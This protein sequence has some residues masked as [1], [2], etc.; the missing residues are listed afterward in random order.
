MYWKT[1]SAMSFFS[2]S[3]NAKIYKQ[4]DNLK[5]VALGNV[6][7][8][9]N[10]EYLVR[11]FIALKDHPVTLHIY[12]KQDE[13]IY[14][15]LQ[16][17]VIEHNLPVEFKGIGSN[18][19]DLLSDYHVYVMSSLHE[20][21]GIATVEAMACNLPLLLS[22]LDVL[23]EV[24]MNNAIFFDIN[25]KEALAGCIKEIIGGKKN[26]QELSLKGLAIAKNY[27]KKQYLQKLFNIYKQ[28]VPSL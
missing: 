4:G 16:D 6:K 5:V 25:N 28:V 23:R 26:L 10:Y 7:H 19:P 13:I 15:R 27:S 3:N 9:K 12:G 2:G 8:Q 24:T 17:L 11:S 20:G 1:I 21:F 18:I 14:P 22:D